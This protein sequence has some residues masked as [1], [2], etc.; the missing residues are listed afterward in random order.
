MIL[1]SCKSV[2]D[3]Q[4]REAVELGARSIGDLT[5]RLGVGIEC[6]ECTSN[7]QEFLNT[8]LNT[9]APDLLATRAAI[10]TPPAPAPIPP[11]SSAPATHS[12]FA[13]DL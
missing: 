12:W 7:V 5:V 1:C 11:E 10:S 6:G 3:Q 13:V 4:I 9:P 8:C 2:S